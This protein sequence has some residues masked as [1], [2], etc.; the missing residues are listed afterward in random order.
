MYVQVPDD[1]EEEEPPPPP[2]ATRPERTKSIYTKPIAEEEVNVN[3]TTLDRNCNP[4]QPAP[5]P[6]ATTSLPSTTPITN[7][8]TTTTPNTTIPRSVY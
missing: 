7:A 3:N 5:T 8:V 4:Q 6:P 2:V 1:E